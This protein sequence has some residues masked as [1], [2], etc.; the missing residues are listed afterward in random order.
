[1]RQGIETV[2]GWAGTPACVNYQARLTRMAGRTGPGTATP[3]T[4]YPRALRHAGPVDE[5]LIRDLVAELPSRFHLLA[6]Q[7]AWDDSG[8]WRIVAPEKEPHIRVSRG[9][10]RANTRYLLNHQPTAILHLHERISPADLLQVTVNGDSVIVWFDHMVTDVI[11]AEAMAAWLAAAYNARS[12]RTAAEVPTE[13]ARYVDFAAWQASMMASPAGRAQVERRWQ[14]TGCYGIPPISAL[15]LAGGR[16]GRVDVIRRMQTVARPAASVGAAREQLRRNGF[17]DFVLSVAA[18]WLALRALS[19]EPKVAV[20]ATFSGRHVRDLQSTL[21]WLAQFMVLGAELPD[22]VTLADVL[23]EARGA[24]VSALTSQG[25][26]YQSLRERAG[27]PAAPGAGSWVHVTTDDDDAG[28]P[29]GPAGLDLEPVP[30]HAP[31][32]HIDHVVV[33]V[34][35]Q[36]QITVTIEY[37]ASHHEDLV[38]NRF[39]GRVRDGLEALLE[40]PRQRAAGLLA[41]RCG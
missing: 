25:V 30:A 7:L 34:R 26:A 20:M 29:A 12:G 33:C 23:R 39:L 1:M 35:W 27:Q 16:R 41:A 6:V 28:A 5:P 37:P 11:G 9:S 3:I 13:R 40:D 32:T 36:A 17:T 10:A 19:S 15:P 2:V 4:L 18:V 38:M 14:L 21:A 24:V 22:D 8:L 31:D